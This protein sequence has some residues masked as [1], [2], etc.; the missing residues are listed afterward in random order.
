MY[1]Q[2]HRVILYDVVAKII[3]DAASWRMTIVSCRLAKSFRD[4]QE[5]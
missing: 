3:C 1:L 5:M 4:S 2:L